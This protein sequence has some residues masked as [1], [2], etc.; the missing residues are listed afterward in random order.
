MRR[1]VNPPTGPAQRVPSRRWLA[2]ALVFPLAA[3]ATEPVG[4][5]PAPPEVEISA[6]TLMRL[7]DS[8]R[9]GGNLAAAAGFY[10]RAHERAPERPEPLVALGT[11]FARMKA[12]GPAAEAYRA[13]IATA[14]ANAEARRGLGSLLLEANEPAQAVAQ[15]EAA[16][17]QGADPRALNGLGI[18]RDLLGDHA[19]A[20]ADYR[21]AL[22]LAGRDPQILNNLGLSLAL[23]G[24]HEAA[25]AL[26][27]ELVRDP[28]AT[29]RFRQNLALAYGLAGRPDAARQL[30]QRDLDPESVQR[31]LGY[32]ELL[33]ALADTGAAA[34][35]LGAH[36]EGEGS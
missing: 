19:Q 8:S 34:G 3:C 24:Q 16:L 17:A 1:P 18:A 31:N 30:G 15:F 4:Q 7:G 11:T 32:Y 20:Q 6:D 21:R 9:D 13:A 5:F 35:A 22:D 26:L 10:H 14:P 36:A 28:Q 25:I 12:I 29:P 27:E 33:R 23:S 2:F